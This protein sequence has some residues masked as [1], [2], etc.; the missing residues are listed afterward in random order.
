MIVSAPK[1]RRARYLEYYDS[2]AEMYPHQI[3]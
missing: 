3:C 2:L 1:M